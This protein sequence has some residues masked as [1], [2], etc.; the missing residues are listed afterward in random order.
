MTYLLAIGDRAY[1]SWS[2]RAWLL[3]DAFGLPVQCRRAQLYTPV[4]AALPTDFPPARTV[5]ALKDE[6]GTVIAESL[7]IAEEL[8]SRHPLAGIWPE[9]PSARAAARM[10]VAEMHAGFTTLRKLC[11]MNLRRAYRDV[12]LPAELGADLDR[13]EEIWAWARAQAGA[14]G[15]WLFGSYSAADA[16]FAPVAARIAGYGLPV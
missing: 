14:E 3:F 10:L 4:F 7:A 11:P 1:S 16:F 13:L 2:L 15:P 8:A 12:P 6:D 5:P 9:L